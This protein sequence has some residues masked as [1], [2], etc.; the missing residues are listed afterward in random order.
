MDRRRFFV[1]LLGFTA[2]AS[3]AAKL[4]TAS[5]ASPSTPVSFRVDVPQATL[6]GILARVRGFDWATVELPD[7]WAYG[8]PRALLRGLAE[9]WADGYD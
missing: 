1:D 3:V 5:A 2:G 7:E 4:R 8:P 6:D 9:R